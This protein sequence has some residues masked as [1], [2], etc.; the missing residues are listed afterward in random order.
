VLKLKRYALSAVQA[1]LLVYLKQEQR[2][3]AQQTIT[4]TLAAASATK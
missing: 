1:I 4:D 3:E 2:E